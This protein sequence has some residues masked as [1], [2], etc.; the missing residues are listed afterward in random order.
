MGVKDTEM[1]SIYGKVYDK[2]IQLIIEIAFEKL[3]N[4]GNLRTSFK[5]YKCSMFVMLF[6]VLNVLRWMQR[7]LYVV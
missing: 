6:L 4:T 3:L 2:I 1:G 5:C 7:A